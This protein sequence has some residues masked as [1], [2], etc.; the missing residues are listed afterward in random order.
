MKTNNFMTVLFL[1]YDNTI[2][3]EEKKLKGEKE[4]E[5]KERERE[6]EREGGKKGEVEGGRRRWKGKESNNKRNGEREERE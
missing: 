4:E 3:H 2:T 6:E 1:R 5:E